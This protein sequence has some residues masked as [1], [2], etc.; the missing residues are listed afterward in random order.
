MIFF[1]GGEEDFVL[2]L[3]KKGAGEI[4]NSDVVQFRIQYSGSKGKWQHA[5]VEARSLPPILLEIMRRAGVGGKGKFTV[6]PGAFFKY[7]NISPFSETEEVAGEFEVMGTIPEDFAKPAYPRKYSVGI[8]LVDHGGSGEPDILGDAPW[9]RK[10]GAWIDQRICRLIKMDGVHQRLWEWVG[11]KSG[12]LIIGKDGVVP[13]EVTAEHLVSTYTGL[14]PWDSAYEVL[15]MADS[16]SNG[17][18]DGE[19]LRDFYL[20]VDEDE[21]GKIGDGEVSPARDVFLSI[22]TASLEGEGGGRS[23]DAGAV[24]KNGKAAKTWEF[25]SRGQAWRTQAGREKASKK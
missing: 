4:L 11:G 5:E 3:E 23:T 9:Y 1:L 13:A 12:M 22:G 16:D 6:K 19:E 10:A 7:A 14:V 15:A 17:L 18:V 21:D 24:F 8:L 2:D 25:W 20:W